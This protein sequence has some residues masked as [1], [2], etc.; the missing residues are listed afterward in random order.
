MIDG[1]IGWDI[2]ASYIQS[3]LNESVGEDVAIHINS[4]GGYVYDAIAI[5]NYIRD[6]ASIHNVEITI[7]GLAA[8]SA[9]YIALASNKK[10]KVHDNSIFMIHNPWIVGIG[11]YREMDKMSEMLKGLTNMFKRAYSRV[12]GVNEIKVES[13]M[14]NE[15]FFFGSEIVDEGFSDNMIES[16]DEEKE[17][18]A[19][20]ASAKLNVQNALKIVKENERSEDLEKIAALIQKPKAQKEEPTNVTEPAGAGKNNGGKTVKTLEE[21]KAQFPDLYAMAIQAGKD[22]GIKQERKRVTA[23]AQ[24]L[25]VDKDNAVKA[26][27]DGED[28]DTTSLSK[29]TKA[30]M[31]LNQVNAAAADNPAGID[32]GAQENNDNADPNA[33]TEEDTKAF[34]ENFLSFVGAGK[35]GK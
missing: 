23:H 1:I 20:I 6:Y 10:P 30:S 12:S 7:D 18:S 34:T 2:T 26:I 22:E 28:F 17:V 21:L 13:W 24:W 33:I 29:Y 3:Q 27:L 11:D 9:S 19:L 4:P 25:D 14:N 16:D 5:F 32:T 8:S 15:K 31:N 35:G